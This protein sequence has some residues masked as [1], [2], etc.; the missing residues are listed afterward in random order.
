[1]KT[2]LI[3]EDMSDVRAWLVDII[4]TVFNDANIIEADTVQQA[5]DAVDKYTF[6]L[7]LIDLNLPDGSGL[8]LLQSLRDSSP[9]TYAIIATIFDDDENIFRAL[10]MGAQGYLLKQ[11]SRDYLVASLQGIL[12][13]EP[14]LS[15]HVARRI[16]QHFRQQSPQ[17]ELPDP[18]LT[19]RE[20]EILTL[21]NKGLVRNEIATT[22]GISPTTVAT[23]ISGIYRKLNVCSRSEA[24]I[25]AVRLGLVKL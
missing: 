24:A 12:A 5:L 23:H 6:E 15:P 8:R 18:G 7:A 25:E 3:L 17:P 11:E 21:I 2:I 4:Q 19:P 9:Q 10:Q 22:L 14:P 13:G 16:L 20:T 1:M